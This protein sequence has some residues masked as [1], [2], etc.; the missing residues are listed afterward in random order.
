[1]L[2]CLVFFSSQISFNRI[3]LLKYR[4]SV[5][6]MSQRMMYSLS[7]LC[8]LM[9][10][11]AISVTA[12]AP[13]GNCTTCLPN[14]IA[15]VYPYNVTGTINATTS[16]LLVSIPYAR[17]LLPARFANSILTHAY[18]RF[19]ILKDRYPIVVEATIH[20]D[21]RFDGTNAIAD[22]SSFRITFPFIDLLGDGYSNFRYTGF[23]Y[24]PA[25]NAI[26]IGGAKAYGETVLPAFFDPPDAPYEATNDGRQ[27]SLAV[28]TTDITLM[29]PESN[30]LV[31][32]LSSKIPAE[33]LP[34]PWPS[35]R[36]LRTSRCLVI[37]PVFATTRY[38]SGTPIPLQAH[39]SREVWLV[40][41][42]LARLWCHRDD[43]S[44]A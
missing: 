15:T 9:P 17:S 42:L 27:T 13:Q 1:M 19:S 23:I 11:L 14:P 41:C 30:R 40:M 35:S 25:D 7:I 16:I 33:S 24:L 29:H 38:R 43:F 31:E 20:H 18:T 12:V 32:G 6:R 34:C 2:Q 8:L 36:T 3:I 5:A 4:G 22:F 44:E 10:L 28:Y 39:T 37:I 26:A 21:I